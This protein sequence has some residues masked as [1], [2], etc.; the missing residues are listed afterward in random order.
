MTLL[1]DLF[2]GA[3]GATLGMHAV[4]PNETIVGLDNWADA[5]RTHKAA[6]FPTVQADLTTFPREQIR[7]R[8]EGMWLSPPCTDFSL[9]GKRSGIDGD[10][11]WLIFTAR[12]WF[13]DIKPDWAVFEQVPAVLRWWRAFAHDFRQLGYKTW[14]GILNAADFGVP[15]TRERAILLAT[16]DAIDFPEPTHAEVAQ[17][18][19]DGTELPWVT[20]AQALGWGD[21]GWWEKRPSTTI[22]SANPGIVNPYGGGTRISQS[23]R[24]YIPWVHQRPATTVMGDR[25]IMAPDGHHP[26]MGMGHASSRAITVTLKELAV[27]QDFP[28]DHPFQGTKTSIVQQIGNAVP[29]RL[30]EVC[31]RA[32]SKAH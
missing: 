18:R 26:E 22:C 30:A 7:G 4:H 19:L 25:R 9:A 5:C 10:T 11:G 17:M 27:L 29:P 13:E 23:A 15:Q 3:G 32:V 21:E 14:A 24:G 6:G 12:H 2:S 16:R 8:V 31:V 28:V 1:L 20:M